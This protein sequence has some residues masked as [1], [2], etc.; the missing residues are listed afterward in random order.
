MKSN[1]EFILDIIENCISKISMLLCLTFVVLTFWQ[2]LLSIATMTSYPFDVWKTT[3]VYILCL[4]NIHYESQTL[5][6]DDY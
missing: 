3:L 2:S 5:L 1:T 6:E 4:L